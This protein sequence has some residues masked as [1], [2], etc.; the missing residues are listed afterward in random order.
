MAL[1]PH[2]RQQVAERLQQATTRLPA[3][4]VQEMGPIAT[5]MGEIFMYTVDAEPRARTWLALAT[6]LLHDQ[7]PPDSCQ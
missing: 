5:G 7:L 6:R 1:E 3:G 4:V 2:R